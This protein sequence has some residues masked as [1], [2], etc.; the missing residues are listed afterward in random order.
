MATKS[1][2]ISG[3]GVAMSLIQ[4]LVNAVKNAGGSDEDIHRLT[5]VSR[6]RVGNEWLSCYPLSSSFGTALE[7]VVP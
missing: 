1:S 5:T 7:V 3:M 4:G 6:Y 2:L